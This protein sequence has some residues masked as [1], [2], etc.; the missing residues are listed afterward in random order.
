MRPPRT[1]YICGD[2]RRRTVVWMRDQNDCNYAVGISLFD[3][4]VLRDRERARTDILYFCFHV[5][6]FPPTMRRRDRFS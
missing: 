5:E 4:R 3:G 6:N 1:P 2:G